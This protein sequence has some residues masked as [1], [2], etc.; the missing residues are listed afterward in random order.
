MATNGQQIAQA[1]VAQQAATQAGQG[2]GRLIQG[3]QNAQ[4][5]QA[6]AGISAGE[7]NASQQGEGQAQGSGGNSPGSAGA[8][9]GQGSS[10]GGDSQGSEADSSPIGQNNQPGDGGLTTYEPIYAPQR[11]GGSSSAEV[12]LPGSGQPGDQVIGEENLAPGNPG[13]SRVPYTEVLPD[14]TEAVR[15][16]VENGQ[17]PILLRS[18][19]RKYF[20]SLEP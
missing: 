3:G 6:Q 20:I 8:G 13:E 17:V 16:A 4:G 7:G 10:E 14:Y 18:L 11:L 15:L 1:Q 9:A 2:E 19:I 5:S 12:A